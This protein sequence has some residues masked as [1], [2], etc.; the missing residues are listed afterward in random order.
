MEEWIFDTHAHY[1]DDAFDE[2]REELLKSL[3]SLGIGRIVNVGSDLAGCRGTL[4]LTEQYDFIYGAI[5][6]HPTEC[7]EITED[8]I[9]WIKRESAREKVVAIGEIGR[10]Y[11]WPD[12]DRETQK[13]WFLRQMDLAREVHLPIIIHSREAAQDTY[14]LMRQAHAEEIGGV[15]HCFSYAPEM[16]KRF[17]EMGFYIGIG[18]VLCF[19]NA[20]KIREVCEQ[21]PLDRIVLETDCP[22]LAPPP[23]RG[24]RNN[25]SYLR[26]V[27]PMMAEIKGVSAEEVIH[28]T[29]ENAFALYRMQNGE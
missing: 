17:V 11:Y 6:V 7:A 29:R 8:D 18:G 20:K 21:I 4:A 23:H 25:S 26:Y 3:A 1:D 13:K 19:K 15:V 22:Y 12:V 24:K 10:D 27:V 2:D 14:E 9:Q 28:T 5:G 16:A